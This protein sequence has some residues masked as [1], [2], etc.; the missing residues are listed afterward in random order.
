MHLEESAAFGHR[1]LAI[2]DLDKK[3]NQPF[4]SYCGR[5]TIVFNGEIYNYLE[6]REELITLGYNFT[7]VSDTEVILASYDLWGEECLHKF[8]GMW[9]FSIWDKITKTL[10]AS[11]DRF[12]VK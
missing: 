3:S 1:R 4:V 9:A 2:V 10:F 8:N 11:R 6:L 7:T 12:G 5:Y